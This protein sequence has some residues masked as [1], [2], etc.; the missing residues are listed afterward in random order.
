M[1]FPA[2]PR[3]PG[4]D[5]GPSGGHPP[6]VARGRENPIPS[7]LP[8]TLWGN[9]RAGVTPRRAARNP[10]P[11]REWGERRALADPGIPAP[12]AACCRPLSGPLPRSRWRN[13]APA[14]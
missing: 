4:G 12:S 3:P 11:F 7:L 5:R 9:L 1:A 8:P 14:L 10:V 6:T 13:V 2:L